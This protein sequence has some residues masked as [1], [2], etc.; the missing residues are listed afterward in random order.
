MN[1]TTEIEMTE[2]EQLIAEAGPRLQ[3]MESELYGKTI[4][5][6]MP[7]GKELSILYQATCKTGCDSKW[8]SEYKKLGLKASLTTAGRWRKIYNHFN[9]CPSLWNRF[10]FTGMMTVAEF[11]EDH[12]ECLNHVKQVVM[13]WDGFF[14]LDEAVEYYKTWERVG[15]KEKL[16]QYG[17]YDAL[18]YLAKEGT[19]L[20]IDT[21]E[22]ECWN[23]WD[24][25]ENKKRPFEKLSVEQARQI[26]E[27]EKAKREKAEREEAEKAENLEREKAE[28]AERE[29]AERE[30][31]E[32]EA[33]N[34]DGDE[35]ED[36]PEGT[37][38]FIHQYRV[39]TG[40]AFYHGELSI[41]AF[42]KFLE[43]LRGVFEGELN[44]QTAN[45]PQELA[46]VA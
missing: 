22:T 39:T 8:G 20:A 33:G 21:A 13:E 26:V 42:D 36:G 9:D 7:I 25:D 34:G 29:R 46:A 38:V 32:R 2:L 23:I 4:E 31:A 24:E 10:N 30:E 14:N 18:K 41:D 44:R 28:K 16:T 43:E 11:A 5:T 27:A 45:Q 15:K 40:N 12:P 6:I 3:L 35:D 19:D 1:A 37:P 17:Q